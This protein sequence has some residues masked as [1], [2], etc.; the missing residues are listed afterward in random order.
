MS[1]LMR[2]VKA[3][4]S[5]WIHDT[6]PQPGAFAWQEGYSAFSA[7]K[8]QQEAAK[9]HI[10]DQHEHHRWEDFKSELSKLLRAHGI[11]SDEKYVFG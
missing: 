9:K 11:E 7:S 10:T 6:F 1:N 3:G 5:E 8:S 4:S 2:T